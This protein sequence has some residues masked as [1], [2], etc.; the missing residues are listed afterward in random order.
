MIRSVVS[1]NSEMTG[2]LCINT[3]RALIQSTRIHDHVKSI[4]QTQRDISLTVSGIDQRLTNMV[5][6]L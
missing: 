1:Q 3:E 2:V 5:Y 4:D 6:A